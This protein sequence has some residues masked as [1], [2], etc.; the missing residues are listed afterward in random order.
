KYRQCFT[1]K[2]VD[3][4]R[5]D[6]LFSTALVYEKP[7]I[8]L[9]MAIGRLL[10]PYQLTGERAAVYKAYIKDNLQ[11]CGKFYLGK[12]EQNQVLTYLGELGLWTREDLD[13]VL[14]QASQRGQIEAVSLLMEEKRKYFPQRPVKDFQL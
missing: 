11:L 14:S 4:Q 13:E 10:W 2:K 3:F 12:E 1:D 5:Y 9:P 8:L 6:K 7:E